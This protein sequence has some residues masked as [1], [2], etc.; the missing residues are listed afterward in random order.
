MSTPPDGKLSS[1]LQAIRSAIASMQNPPHAPGNDNKSPCVGIIQDIK[2]PGFKDYDTLGLFHSTSAKGINDDNKLLVERLVQL[3]SKLPPPSTEL[4]QLSDGFIN[5]LWN[6][7][8][9]PPASSL[10]DQYQ[11]R[12]ADGSHSN[13]NDPQLEAANTSY[14]RSVRPIVLQK[15]DLPDPGTIFDKLSTDSF[16]LKPL[17]DINI[18]MKDFVRTILALNRAD[19]TWSLDPR[20]KEGKT[21]FSKGVPAGTGNF[22]SAEFN[23]LYRWHSTISP[24]DEKWAI[25]EFKRLL[26]GKVPETASTNDFLGAL[27]A[28]HASMPSGP[29]A[30]TFENLKKLP[31]GTFSDDD[32]VKTLTDSIEDISG[33]FGANKVSRC[34]RSIEVLGILQARSWNLGTLNEFRE[35]VGLAKHATFEDI[36][37]DPEVASRLKQLYDTPD[38]VEMYPGIVAEKTKP[39]MSPGSG[40]C[41]TVTMTTAILSD[42]VAL[43]R[44]DRFYTID[45]TPK[46]LTNW[47]FNEVNCDVAIDNG[48]VIHKLIFR[49]SPNH[50]VNNSIYAH[51][52]L[53]SPWENIKILKDLGKE[54]QY[55]WEKPRRRRDL[56]TIES[57][58]ACTHILSHP[59]DFKVTWG[60]AITFL[61]MRDNGMVPA[62][63][64]CL[65]GDGIANASNRDHIQKCLYPDNWDNDINNF[66]A[67]TTDR[68]LDQFGSSVASQTGLHPPNVPK[69]TRTREVDIVRNV[70]A[71]ATTRFSAALW[72][73][74]MTTQESPGGA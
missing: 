33:S 60:E 27:A 68:L 35:F 1:L 39:P 3:L 9:H 20:A 69:D 38:S 10:G 18:V 67:V 63:E 24:K 43:V 59:K 71:L 26:K 56:T 49:A 17:H 72:S 30:R 28:W 42:A 41:G 2:R 8:D 64:F 73:L 70:I 47:G 66:V 32:L 13:I 16:L 25:A 12:Q 14:A 21:V 37:P 31:D 36:N 34:M 29:E 48:H 22:V 65:S 4:K 6:T 50:F 19:T 54:S 45:Y 58:K 55:S 57:Y 62:C 15:P 53:V 61:S 5:Q 11:Y 23:L 74:P 52:P 40:L 51:F 7:L 44:G 46:P